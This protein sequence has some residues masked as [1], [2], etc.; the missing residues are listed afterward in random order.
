MIR[1]IG[2]ME[3]DESL[4]RFNEGL[5]FLGVVDRFWWLVYSLWQCVGQSF[6]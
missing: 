4:G 3:W 5:K 1:V 6:V 2:V